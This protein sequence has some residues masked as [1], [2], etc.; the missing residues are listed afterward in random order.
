MSEAK[1]EKV[2]E[3]KEQEVVE[4]ILTEDSF[5]KLNMFVPNTSIVRCPEL[6]PL[7]GLEPPK[8]A[9]IKVQ[10][11][12]LGKFLQITGEVNDM[13]RNLM[14]GVLAAAVDKKEVEDEVLRLWTKMN[15]D[16]QKTIRL[17]QEGIVEPKLSRSYIISI[18]RNFPDV[19][20]R[21]AAKIRELTNK[22]AVLKKNSKD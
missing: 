5:K 2:V 3:K 22:G 7:M 17:M 12:T 18:S 15:P 21:I 19:A 6:N 8:C 1:K 11:L 4:E 14:E 13:I 20:S 16:E 10:Q 9:V